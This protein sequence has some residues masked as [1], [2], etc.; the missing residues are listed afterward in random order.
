MTKLQLFTI[1]EGGP[2]EL[3]VPEGATQFAHLYR[4][5]PLGAYTALRTFENDK[6]L[7]LERHLART[8]RSLTLLGIEYALDRG[9]LRR[10]LHDIV[11]AARRPEMRV[12]IDVLAAAPAGET[13]AA[14]GT[15]SRE[16]IAIQP[17][18]PP[19]PELY[20]RGV[21]VDFAAGLARENPLAKAAEFAAQRPASAGLSQLEGR[22]AKATAEPYEYLLLDDRGRILEG[23]GTN[24]W[25]VRD[26]V[27]YTAGEGV[28]EGITREIVLQIIDQLGIPLRLEAVRADEVGSLDEAALSGSS[29]A[30]M[31]VVSI[32]GQSVGDGRPGPVAGRILRAYHAFVA[33]NIRQAV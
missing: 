32:S 9:R 29:R 7:Y 10:A 28:L 12:R 23:T 26:G 1:E 6:F 11:T 13:A 27:V 8:E 21:A 22:A 17:F 33:G 2:R 24:F 3:A 18:T 31:P 30:F 14:L 4:G 19:P 5:L 16:L 15:T 20:E 25:A